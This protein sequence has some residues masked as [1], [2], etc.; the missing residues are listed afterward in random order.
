MAEQKA[1]YTLATEADSGY[2]ST[3]EGRCTAEAKL[4]EKNTWYLLTERALSVG[5]P[6]TTRALTKTLLKSFR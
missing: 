3:A 4:K 5:V 6:V 2:E 1:N